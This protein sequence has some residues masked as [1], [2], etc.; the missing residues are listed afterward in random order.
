MF[1][2]S[3]WARSTLTFRALGVAGALWFLSESLGAL[4]WPV[5]VV[6]DESNTQFPQNGNRLL[7][8]LYAVETV[9]QWKAIGRWFGEHAMSLVLTAMG[10]TLA[11]LPP[12]HI[13]RLLARL[14]GSKHD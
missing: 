8:L 10:M 11:I 1:I 7:R 2:R 9:W 13:Q 3:G 6:V 4:W 12:P 14:E 5:K